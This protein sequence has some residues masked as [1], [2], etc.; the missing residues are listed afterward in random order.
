MLKKIYHQVF[1]AKE[2]VFFVPFGISKTHVCAQSFVINQLLGVLRITLCSIRD[3][4]YTKC[5]WS[6]SAILW[7]VFIREK[8]KI[9]YVDPI[10]MEWI[11]I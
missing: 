11:W 4:L 1:C 10:T 2:D 9:I 5:F 6:H 8:H 3:D 7:V